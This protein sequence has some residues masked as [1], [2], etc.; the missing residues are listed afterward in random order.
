MKF[1][2][3]IHELDRFMKVSFLVLIGF[4]LGLDSALAQNGGLGGAATRFQEETVIPLLQFAV[5]VFY[6]VG[7][8]VVGVGINKFMKVSKGDPQTSPGEAAGYAFGGGGLMALGFIADYA[9]TSMATGNQDAGGWTNRTS[10]L[11]DLT[12]Q[13]LA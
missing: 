4:C 1:K 9:A 11:L 6:A 10:M 12:L 5:Y 2:L 13:Y 7:V 3:N 8:C